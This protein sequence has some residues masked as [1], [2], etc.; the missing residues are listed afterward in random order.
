M[1][2][3]RQN[4]VQLRTPCELRANGR[5]VSATLLDL[6]EGGLSVRLVEDEELEQGTP[7]VVI[8]GLPRGKTS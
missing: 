1:D 6:S 3:R 7:T 8:L 4:R 5:T 2:R